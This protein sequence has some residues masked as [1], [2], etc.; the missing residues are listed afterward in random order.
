[1]VFLLSDM[2]QFIFKKGFPESSAGKEFAWN[3]GDPGSIPGSGR[4]SGERTGHPLQDSW[5]FL[6]TQMVKNLP[7]IR[8]RSVQSLGL[9]DPLEKGTATHSS[10]LS[11]RIPLTEESGGLQSMGSQRVGH[12][13]ATFYFSYAVYNNTLLKEMEGLLCGSVVMNPPASAGDTGSV[14]GLGRSHMLGNEAQAPQE[15]PL[16]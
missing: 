10:F 11:W 15:K 6:V 2:P 7:A 8:E 9:E 12:N 14:P 16:Q 3:A 4:S 1:M 5:A 13:G